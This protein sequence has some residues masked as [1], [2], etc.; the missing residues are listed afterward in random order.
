MKRPRE[1]TSWKTWI[2]EF[3]G[4]DEGRSSRISA[5]SKTGRAARRPPFPLN[6]VRLD[7]S[8]QSVANAP[9]RMRKTHGRRAV[10]IEVG[11]TVVLGGH[12]A[13]AIVHRGVLIVVVG[14]GIGAPVAV[15]GAALVIEQGDGRVVAG[16]AVGAAEGGAVGCTRRSVVHPAALPVV[17]IVVVERRQDESSSTPT[18]GA[19]REHIA[20]DADLLKGQGAASS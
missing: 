16:H 12:L 6:S 5:G 13:G 17:R 9:S 3:M 20:Q 4:V 1:P 19:G 14:L 2:R 8:S 10:V 11:G 7:Y 15:V 18:V